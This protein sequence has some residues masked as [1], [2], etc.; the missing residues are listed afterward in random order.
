MIRQPRALTLIEVLAAMGVLIVGMTAIAT[1]LFTSS[2]FGRIAAERNTVAA[3]IP[4][5]IADIERRH[6]ITE[7]MARANPTGTFTAP[8]QDVG[9][10]IETVNSELSAPDN[11]N[12]HD[13][14]YGNIAV[15]GNTV[16]LGKSLEAPFL[17]SPDTT[18][19]HFGIWPL[20]GES[21]KY[22]GG[23][24]RLN[25]DVWESS[26]VAIRILYRLERHPDWHDHTSVIDPAQPL[27]GSVSYTLPNPVDNSPY[28][29]IY[30]LTM[31]VYRQL[32][33][34]M[35]SI[36]QLAEPYVVHIRDRKVRY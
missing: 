27:Y 3:I 2:R 4:E 22:L 25:A 11:P 26:S 5:A 8:P 14:N 10:L 29:G 17:D 34:D 19:I 33:R 18:K 36:Q 35:R 32:D 30:V 12:I 13:A 28:R 7:N 24:A 6:L 16:W 9:L 1:M 20:P 23:N 21:P 15:S 31:V